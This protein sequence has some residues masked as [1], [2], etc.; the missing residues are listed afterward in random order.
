MSTSNTITKTDLQNII[1]A[2]FP[3]TTED[4][5]EAQIDAF[6][7][8]LDCQKQATV[9]ESIT[10]FSTGWSEYT[11]GEY[12]KLIKCGN[13]VTLSGSMKNTSAITV[14]DTGKLIFTIPADY[15]PSYEIRG[16]VFLSS[17]TNRYGVSVYT[18]GGVYVERCTNGTSYSSMSAGSWFPFHITW[19]KE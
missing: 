14:N 5:T 18:D 10:S 1:N 6:I 9:T 2:I 19:V 11:T 13:I 4:M 15:R 8:S 12:P 3:A 16:V 17:G 7:D